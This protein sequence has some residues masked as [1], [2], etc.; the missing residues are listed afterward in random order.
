MTVNKKTYYRDDTPTGHWQRGWKLCPTH[1]CGSR[2]H[3][4]QG[5]CGPR[6]DAR[7]M[8]SNVYSA[9]NHPGRL[10]QAIQRSDAFRWP[11]W[12]KWAS[13]CPTY[14]TTSKTQ[15][16]PKRPGWWL[17]PGSGPLLIA[18][19][20]SYAGRNR[21]IRVDQSPHWAVV[22]SCWFTFQLSPTTSTSDVW[23]S[24]DIQRSTS[25]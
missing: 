11:S 7:L 15:K 13:S 12:K 20:R 5:W 1:C 25:H 3:W 6:H 23:R 16:Q 22:G 10:F 17:G 21:S 18:G 9:E 8:S 19:S 14:Q 2:Q 24:K 4:Q